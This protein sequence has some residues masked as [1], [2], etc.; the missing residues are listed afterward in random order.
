V[1]DVAT[2]REVPVEEKYAKPVTTN[3]PNMPINPDDPNDKMRA[4]GPEVADPATEAAHQ[5]RAAELAAQ[6]P[7]ADPEE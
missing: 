2:P 6:E 1:S 7:P 3:D 4:E 5:L